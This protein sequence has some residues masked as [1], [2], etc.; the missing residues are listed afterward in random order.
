[1]QIQTEDILNAIGELETN[2]IL[3]VDHQG[4]IR[5]M[6]K[7]VTA[8]LGYTETDLIGRKVEVI[9]QKD[10][11]KNHEEKFQDYV[12]HRKME[13]VTRSNLIGIQ[14][15][16][17]SAEPLHHN[18]DIPFA[19]V[20]KNGCNLP[21]TLTI[22]EI[23]SDSDDLLGFLA[24]I[25]DNTKQF[26]LHQKLKNQA[27][28]DPLTGLMTWHQF[29][30]TV[31]ETKKNALA[32]KKGY[33]A[34][35]LFLDVDY[36]RTITYG[37]QMAGDRALK[38]I[39]N[40]LL[41]QIRQKGTRPKDIVTARFLGDQFI[42]YLSD[43][44]VDGALALARR[45]KESF[46]TLNLRTEESP[47]FTSISQGVT[48]ITRDTRLHNA[49]S[50][51]AHACSLA[52]K[53]GRNKIETVLD[54]GPGYLGLERIIREALQ[55]RRLILFA[56]QIVPIS[57]YART[58]DNN[59]AHYEVLSRILDPKGNL[60]SPELFIP[61]AEVLGLAVDVD[62][63]VIEH[64]MTTLQKHPGHVACL[65]LC[66]INL[67]GLSVSREGTYAFIEKTIRASGIDPGKFCFEF[68]ETAE[69]KDNDVAL[70]LVRR[71]KK[72]G[73][74][75]AFDDFGIGYSNYQSFSRLPMDI[76][77]ID[78]SYVKK[79]LKDPYLKT[80][81]QGMIHSAKVRNIEVVAEFAENKAITE[82]LKQ[83]GVDYAQGY[84]YSQPKPLSDVIKGTT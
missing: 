14:K 48:P 79:I 52:K 57:P 64:T 32:D 66:S 68:T 63:Y 65:S 29:E 13:V 40:W 4:I 84:Y 16:F 58:I 50:L 70:D 15:T 7:G 33:Q 82:Q 53:K 43:T 30:K 17:P 76:I 55:Q 81:M 73:C 22:N 74:K 9:L 51:A 1:V 34:A 20:D 42:L 37:S 2:A 39:A 67:S 38:R 44:S 35:M 10:F 36:F 19:L 3:V 62:R 83:L 6:N 72:L 56:Q 54:E 60:L 47:F 77:K 18:D 25:S 71:L 27:S 45:L 41:N 5:R 24:I 59:R 23:W 75:T 12:S 46:I 49:A 21:I 8:V 31:N 69:I 28:Y 80:D 61:A 26:N 11:Q 78:G